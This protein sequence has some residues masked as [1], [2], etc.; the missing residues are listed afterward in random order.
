MK[1]LFASLIFAVPLI[2]GGAYI[3]TPAFCRG[4]VCDSDTALYRLFASP[5]PSGSAFR[6]A[7]LLFLGISAFIAYLIVSESDG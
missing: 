5:D 1:K 4:S 6:F 7:V 2:A 3:V